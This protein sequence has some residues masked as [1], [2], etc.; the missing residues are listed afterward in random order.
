ML[1]SLTKNENKKIKMKNKV[2]CLIIY[3]DITADLYMQYIRS[4]EEWT[5]W[6]IWGDKHSEHALIEERDCSAF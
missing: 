2:F 3:C 6:L 5:K 1:Y 4:L